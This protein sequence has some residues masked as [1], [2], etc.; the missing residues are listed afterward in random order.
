MPTVKR[1]LRN[2]HTALSV[3][4]ALETEPDDLLKITTQQNVL[5]QMQHLRTHPSVAA[6][7]Q[8]GEISLSGWL[9]DIAEGSVS[10]VEHDQRVFEPVLPEG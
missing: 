1:W 3:T 8:R 10:I 7:L 4:E 2:A 6:G 5:L 9:Y